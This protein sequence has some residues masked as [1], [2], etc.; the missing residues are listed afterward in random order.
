MSVLSLAYIVV[1][2]FAAPPNTWLSKCANSTYALLFTLQ[3][4]AWAFAGFLMVFE[5]QRLLSEAWYANQLFW[6]LN[7]MA[8]IA[9]IVTLRQEIL[10]SVFMICTASINVAMNTLCVVL[11][12][13]T[14]RRTIYNRRLN[15]EEEYLLL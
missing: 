9:T 1:V 2:I 6:T 10:S 7:L 15:V 12:L 11:M 3:A 5:Y 14:E 13:K 4:A 8:V